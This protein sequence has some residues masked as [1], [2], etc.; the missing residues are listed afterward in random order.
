MRFNSTAAQDGWI[1]ESGMNTKIGGSLNSSAATLQ[2][3]DNAVKKQYLSI[4]SFNTANLPDTAV[5]TKV[6]L[7][8]QKQSVTG[9]GNPVAI[10]QGFMVDIKKG[11][12]GTTSL[13]TSDFQAAPSKSY[14]P[15]NTAITGTWYNIDITNAKAYINKLAANGGLTQIRLRFNL[16]NDSNTIANYLSLFSGEAPLASR[17]A[18]IIQYYVP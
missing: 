16:N 2:I 14:G 11:F 18:L 6:T 8:V 13:Q 15:F 3:G 1:L 10:F 17:P 7:K 12:F 4:L 9:G 5:I